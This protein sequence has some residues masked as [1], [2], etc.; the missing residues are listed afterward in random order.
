MRNDSVTRKETTGSQAESLRTDRPG[1][2]LEPHTGWT[3]R[4]YLPHLNR[5]GLVQG[6]TFRL[7]DSLPGHIAASLA[8]EATDVP[9]GA[10]RARIEAYL[11]AGYGACTLRDPSIAGLVQSALL[12]FDGI[13]YRL[14]AWVVMPNHVHVLIETIEGHPLQRI[15][16]SWKSF[17]ANKA[18]Q[19]LGRSGRFWFPDYFD[20]YVRDE[21]HLNNAV[22]TI[23]WNPVKAGLVESPD[24][25]PFSS[26]S[27]ALGGSGRG[28]GCR[29]G[30]DARDPT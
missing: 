3:S 12:F 11:N 5:P 10:K 29:C 8:E 2:G 22:R 18:N 6:I 25:W 15:V 1:S 13:R 9:E 27:W 20:R 19:I 21:R 14:I 26:A 24:D 23:H 17:T 28:V 4:G 30:Q 7:W 16:H